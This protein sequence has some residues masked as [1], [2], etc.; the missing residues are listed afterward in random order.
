MWSI[1]IATAQEI[2]RVDGCEKARDRQLQQGVCHG[3][4]P[5]GAPLAV[6][7]WAIVPSDQLGPVVLPLQTLH[8]V[9]D[10]L[11]QIPLV[12]LRAHLIDPVGGVFADVPPALLEQCLVEPPIAVAIGPTRRLPRLGSGLHLCQ[13]FPIRG[14]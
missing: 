4:Y 14:S 13:G 3:R 2:L 11:L 1:P 10:V 12:C 6:P 5:S 7:F 9:A 8:Q